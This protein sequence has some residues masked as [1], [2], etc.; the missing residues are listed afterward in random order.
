MVPLD[1]GQLSVAKHVVAGAK[2]LTVL[3]GA[4]ISAE[5][6]IP[7]FRG[8]D[9]YWRGHSPEELASMDGFLKNPQLVWEW[10]LERRRTIRSCQPNPGHDALAFLDSRKEFCGV[11]TQNVDGLHKLAGSQNLIEIHGNI[12]LTQCISCPYKVDESQSPITFR[13]NCPECDSLLRPGVV[14]FGEELPSGGW[15]QANEWVKDSE[16][17]IVVGTSA[18]V[19]PAANLIP[20][21]RDAGS[22]IIEVNISNT[23]ASSTADI[24]LYGKAAEILPLLVDMKAP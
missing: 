17:L 20:I 5:S 23:P 10:Y 8:P 6:G 22:Y 7:T 11:V 12:W 4:G 19:Y 24:C 9:G 13:L 15:Q 3:T 2:R 16:L 18:V 1:H 21:A 14:W